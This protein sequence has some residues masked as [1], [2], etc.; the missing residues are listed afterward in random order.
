MN[1]SARHYKLERAAV[2]AHEVGHAVQHA[3][4]YSALQMRSALVPVVSV[5]SGMSQ[6]PVIGGLILGATAGFG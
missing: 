3:Q 6:W 4:A 2:A 5:T 1:A